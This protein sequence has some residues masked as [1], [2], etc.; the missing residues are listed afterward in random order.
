MVKQIS[1]GKVYA[2]RYADV[3]FDERP[4]SGPSTMTLGEAVSLTDKASASIMDTTNTVSSQK[5]DKTVKFAQ[6]DDKKRYE[7]RGYW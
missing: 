1:N 6:D 2:R 7:S 3:D 4:K 5:M